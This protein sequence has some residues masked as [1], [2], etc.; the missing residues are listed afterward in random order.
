MEMA[1]RPRKSN[2]TL[3]SLGTGLTRL[4]W[5]VAPDPHT[6]GSCQALADVFP[7]IW[8]WLFLCP[9]PHPHLAND[10]P[11]ERRTLHRGL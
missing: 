8:G 2:I 5:K 7:G 11:H 9:I 3:G 6:H 1:E 10:S 4:F